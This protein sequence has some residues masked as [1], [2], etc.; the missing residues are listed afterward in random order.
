MAD[1]GPGGAAPSG[2]RGYDAILWTDGAARGNPGPAGI[3][4]LL[5]T[6]SGEILAADSAYLG[7]ATN[8]VA[9]YKALLMGLSRALALGVRRIEIR[10]DSELL[11]KQI[12][13]QYRVKSPGL[14][15]LF[16]AAIQL[17]ARFESSRLVHVR[18]EQNSEADR[19]ANAGIDSR[20]R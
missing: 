15:P 13:G 2:E 4:A 14:L 18:R 17:L 7:E 19:L 10:A 5:K 8:N 9:E 20:P 1:E 16:Q 12:K 11:V 6:P 3:G